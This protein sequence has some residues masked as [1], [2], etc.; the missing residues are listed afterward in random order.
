MVGRRDRSQP[1]GQWPDKERGCNQ[2]GLVAIAR[3]DPA[4]V[5][6]SPGRFPAVSKRGYG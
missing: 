2:D 1:S 4:L 6:L 5:A 3:L